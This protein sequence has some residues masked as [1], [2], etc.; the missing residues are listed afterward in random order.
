MRGHSIYQA[1]NETMTLVGSPYGQIRA[2]RLG[3]RPFAGH[4]TESL[5]RKLAC[6]SLLQKTEEKI[7][8]EIE[9]RARNEIRGRS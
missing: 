5:H 7:R 9:W 8:N 3:E 6:G 1:P 4:S 2:Q